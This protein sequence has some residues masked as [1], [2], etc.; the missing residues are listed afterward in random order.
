[1]S[2]GADAVVHTIYE[3]PECKYVNSTEYQQPGGGIPETLNLNPTPRTLI[4]NP[5]P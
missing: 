1:V 5:G 3:D 2:A 4:P